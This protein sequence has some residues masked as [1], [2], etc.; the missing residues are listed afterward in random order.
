MHDL[1]LYGACK[2]PIKFA[3]SGLWQTALNQYKMRKSRP[4]AAIQPLLVFNMAPDVYCEMQ[5]NACIY[6][7]YWVNCVISAL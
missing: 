2:N 6:F 1:L 3:P 5:K 7:G 4:R